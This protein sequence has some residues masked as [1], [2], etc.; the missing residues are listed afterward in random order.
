MR[1]TNGCMP[2]T[3]SSSRTLAFGALAVSICGAAALY[4]SRSGNQSAANA[5]V[6][7]TQDAQ[8]APSDVRELAASAEGARPSANAS[9]AE[10]PARQ[11]QEFER[12]PDPPQPPELMLQGVQLPPPLLDAETAFAA[13]PIDPP[14]ASKTEAHI[15]QEIAVLADRPMSTLQVQCRTTICRL[16]VVEPDQPRSEAREIGDGLPASVTASVSWMQEMFKRSG[17]E[18]RGAMSVPNR[19]GSRVLVAYFARGAPDAD[20]NDPPAT[21]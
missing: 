2:L 9:V 12:R 15:L 19:F 16:Q 7:P 17:L 3:R 8:V 11:P 1:L 20:A 10:S 13:E 18:S 5:V 4:V 21:R 14:W 6:Q